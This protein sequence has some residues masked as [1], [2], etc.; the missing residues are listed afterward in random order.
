MVMNKKMQIRMM[1]VKIKKMKVSPDLIDLD[2]RIDSTLNF[3]ENWRIIKPKLF[4]RR[5]AIMY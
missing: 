1:K 2:A 5:Y 4:S 3:N